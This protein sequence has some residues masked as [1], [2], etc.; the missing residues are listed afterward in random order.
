ME[1]EENYTLTAS[2]PGIDPADIDV[3]F[4]DGLLT[5]RGEAK[6][7]K[8]VNAEDFRLRERRYGTFSRS[9]RFPVEVQA[10]HIEASYEQGLLT[11]TLPKAEEV[12]PKR[13]AVNV[14]AK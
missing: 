5:I 1:N 11:L 14:N 8:S 7:D 6:V 4:E 2:V 3:T 10:D 9:I 13:I 12:K